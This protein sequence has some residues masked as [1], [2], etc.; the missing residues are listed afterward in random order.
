M[1]FFAEQNLK[2]LGVT[3]S[4]SL[5][6]TV[7]IFYVMQMLIDVGDVQLD[8]KSIKIADVTMPERELELML[9]LIHI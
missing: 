9:S 6:L 4:G 5:F 2:M 8:D 1:G 7:V 3:L